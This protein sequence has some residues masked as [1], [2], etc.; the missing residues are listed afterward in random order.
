[1]GEE[2]KS[3]SDNWPGELAGSSP[4]RILSF[5]SYILV[6]KPR[7]GEDDVN[8]ALSGSRKRAEYGDGRCLCWLGS[9]LKRGRWAEQD[10]KEPPVFSNW[11]LQLAAELGDPSAQLDLSI[12]YSLDGGCLKRDCALS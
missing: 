3:A 8:R 4:A 6:R 9:I 10:S 2:K 1:M 5:A 12:A 11:H 7:P